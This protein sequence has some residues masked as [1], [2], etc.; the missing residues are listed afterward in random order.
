M[1]LPKLHHYIPQFL[2]RNF[3]MNEK[4]Q[5]YV[6][7]KHKN[8]TFT[9]NPSKIAAING[10]YNFDFD[11]ISLSLEPGLAELEGKVAN[12]FRRIIR[13]KKLN[14]WNPFERGHIARFLAIQLVRT[15]AIIAQSKDFETRMEA[16]LRSEGMHEDFFKIDSKLGT[17]EN[18]ERV[19]MARNIYNAPKDYGPLISRKDWILFET[20]IEQPFLIGDHPIVM[21]NSKDM[22]LR[23]N[24][25]L[26]VEGIEIYMPLSP[27]LTLG[28]MCPSHRQEIVKG[29]KNLCK[30]SKKSPDSVSSYIPTWVE[31]LDILKAIKK[32]VPL[33]AKSENVDF[34]N[35]LQISTAERFIFSKEKDFSLAVSMIERH[36]SIK[37]G[38]RMEEANRK[39]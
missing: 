2:L 11:G 15:P 17:P 26:K 24:L 3:S 5:L 19:S 28:I 10:Y 34:F 38:R 13:N 4:K 32:G 18:A 33:K 29:V 1:N 21:H 16:W 30:A 37:H 20:S 9:T 6:F 35:S 25:G 14:P 36:P 39:F 12:Y 31:V 7:D 22:G 8:S 27:T 23:G